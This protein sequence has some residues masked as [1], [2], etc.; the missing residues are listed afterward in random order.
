MPVAGQRDPA[1][2]KV[3]LEKWMASKMPEASDVEIT[4]LVVPQSSGFSNE[5]FLLDARWVEAD[6]TPTEARLVLRSQPAMHHLFP[7]IDLIAQQYQT[8]TQLGLHSDVPVPRTRWAEPDPELLGGQFF[9]MDRLD[10]LVPGDA[11]PYTQ[12]G[13][14]FDMTPEQRNEWHRNAIGAL[15]KVGRVDWKAAELGYLAKPHFGELGPEQRKGY[16]Q[17]YKDFATKGEA[18]PVVDPA[19]DWLLANWPDD[20]EHIELCWGDARPGNQMFDGTE[21]IGVF[22]WEMVSLGNSESDLGWWLFLQR[23]HTDGSDAELLPGM[24]DRAETIALWEELAGRPATHVDFYEILGGWQFC[25]VMCKLAE[26]YTLE[27]GAE[28]VGPMATHNPVSII[29]AELLGI[30]I[31][32]PPSPVVR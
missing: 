30:E 21:V 11:P 6:G 10:G 7:E 12:E 4:E 25:L 1:Q 24:L 26:M 19:W 14:V 5:T 16:F 18:H 13:F 20:G 31:P 27:H 15:A 2:V 3:V 32:P 8:M 9:V 22:D 28:A 23:F 17:L 29:T